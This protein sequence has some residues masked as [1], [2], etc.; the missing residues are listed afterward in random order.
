MRAHIH[1]SAPYSCWPNNSC[2]D[3][4]HANSEYM[5]VLYILSNVY[6]DLHA[7]A[8][9]VGSI[10]TGRAVTLTEQ[11]KKKVVMFPTLQNGDFFLSL[12]LVFWFA[13]RYT[14]DTA[15]APYAALLPIH[16]QKVPRVGKGVSPAYIT[17][18]VL[19]VPA[20]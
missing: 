13:T 15:A 20:S 14:D 3:S 9:Y 1:T 11:K 5:N 8:V 18:T 4:I 17:F 19:I 2:V 6:S 12:L 7:F 16:Q 10:S